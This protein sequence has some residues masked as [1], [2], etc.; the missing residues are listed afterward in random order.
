MI[1]K[2]RLLEMGQTGA[3]EFFGSLS[4]H[5]RVPTCKISTWHSVALLKYQY[6]AKK[7]LILKGDSIIK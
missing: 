6:F 1:L 4:S 7:K 2:Q 5:D 3:A